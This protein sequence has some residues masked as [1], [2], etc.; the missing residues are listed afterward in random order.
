MRHERVCPGLPELGVGGDPTACLGQALGICPPW[1][2]DL[3]IGFYD[4]L[5]SSAFWATVTPT[6]ERLTGRPARTFSA[7][8]REQADAFAP[9]RQSLR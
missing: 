3:L 5:R 4:A 8:A 6:V 7:W 2:V 9:T 1:Y